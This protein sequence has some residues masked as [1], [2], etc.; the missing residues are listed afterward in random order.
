MA[1]FPDR[2]VLKNSTDAQASIETA[3]GSGGTDAI[4]QGELVV[5]LGA[6][7][8]DIY[9]IDSNGDVVRFSP[10]SAAG[11]AIVS[12][13]AP[14]VGIN[15][16]PLAEG[17]LWFESDTDSYYVY[18]GAAWV[19]VS[20]GGGGSGTVTSI[21][22]A[23][24]TGLSSSG[25]PVTTSGTITLDLDNT[26]V[27]PGSYTSADI[28]VDAQGRITAASNG[29]GGGGG[30][31]VP[32]DAILKYTIGNANNSGEWQYWANFGAN[33]L[34]INP[35]DNTGVDATEMFDYLDAS[36]SVIYIWHSGDNGATWTKRGGTFAS[37]PGNPFYAFNSTTGETSFTG[38]QWFTF[39]DPTQ[40]NRISSNA[41]VDTVTTAPTDGQILVWN[42]TNTQWEPGDY[43]SKATLK[44]E[45]A[46]STDFADFQTRIAAL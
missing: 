15:G 20:G 5:G 23:G 27:T 29:S 21:D 3:I 44:A 38:D 10:T 24:G 36:N 37:S 28:T 41:D 1:V 22:V 45:V 46:A 31:L 17:D 42:N 34:Y 12:D 33:D 19:E 40:P 32:F 9:T 39:A 11:R 7:T 13:T 43:I 4:V 16:N 8:V 30:G 2:I 25:G 18:Y 6:G 26:A 35:V 14:T